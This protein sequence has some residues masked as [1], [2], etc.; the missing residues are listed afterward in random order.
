VFKRIV[1]RQSDFGFPLGGDF[2]R[3][4]TTQ[5]H[6]FQLIDRI[7]GRAASARGPSR[8]PI[9]GTRAAAPGDTPTRLA[10]QPLEHDDGKSAFF[11]G[12]L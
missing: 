1:G 11:W 12:I 4:K 8:P 7:E 6:V 9:A 5:T 3:E 10:E 2:Q